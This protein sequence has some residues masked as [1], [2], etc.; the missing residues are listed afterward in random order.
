MLNHNKGGNMQDE[1]RDMEKWLGIKIDKNSSCYYSL[2][3][4]TM[5]ELND[6]HESLCETIL[7][8]IDLA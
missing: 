7:Y 5:V 1:I 2:E 3:T 4:H 6:Y 8:S